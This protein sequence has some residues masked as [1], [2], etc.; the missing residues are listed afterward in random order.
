MT[1]LTTD[2]SARTLVVQVAA[3]TVAAVRQGDRVSAAPAEASPAGAARAIEAPPVA[4][5]P[6]RPAPTVME[7]PIAGAVRH[8]IVPIPPLRGDRLRLGLPGRVR[9]P[10]AHGVLPAAPTGV[11]ARARSRTGGNPVVVVIVLRGRVPSVSIRR[12]RSVGPPRSVVPVPSVGIRRVRTAGPPRSVGPP[13]TAVPVPSVGIRRVRSVGP[14]RSVAPVPSVGIRRVR[15]VGPPRSVAPVPSVGIRRVRSVGPPRTAVPVPS[16]GIRRVRTAGPPRSVGIRRVRT[17]G[18][19]P[20]VVTTAAP[21][22]PAV[23]IVAVARRRSTTKRL[24]ARGRPAVPRSRSPQGRIR[25]CWTRPC[26]R[27]CGR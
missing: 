7:A 9:L 22:G 4:A 3:G 2:R 25:S 5:G 16:V 20:T 10:A 24:A 12:V 21:S 18:L 13:R 14:P 26:E 11:P 17:A 8:P 23:A 15:S 1:W 27:S 19:V 6:I